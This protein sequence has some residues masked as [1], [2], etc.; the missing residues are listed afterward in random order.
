MQVEF[1]PKIKYVVIR[2]IPI[3]YYVNTDILE[4]YT[5]QLETKEPDTLDWIDGFEEN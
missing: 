5:N 4:S 3:A 2:D 1:I